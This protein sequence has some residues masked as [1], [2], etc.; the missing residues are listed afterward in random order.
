MNESLE[1]GIISLDSESIQDIY[2]TSVSL[3]EQQ[4]VHIWKSSLCAWPWLQHNYCVDMPE[5]TSPFFFN[6]DVPLPKPQM[7]QC[8]FL[9]LC[10][11]FCALCLHFCTLESASPFFHP[12]WWWCERQAMFCCLHKLSALGTLCIPRSK[13]GLS[14][15]LKCP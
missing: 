14:E 13:W 9:L 3:S 6:W 10:Y 7:R 4:H 12:K 11:P 5:T 1:S 2:S 8:L 15:Q